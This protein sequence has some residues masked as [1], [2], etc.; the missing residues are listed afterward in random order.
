[1]MVSMLN[2]P[3]VWYSDILFYIEG[4]RTTDLSGESSRQEN[5]LVMLEKDESLSI[6]KE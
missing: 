4:C 5:V 3:I 2:V 1:M 6:A